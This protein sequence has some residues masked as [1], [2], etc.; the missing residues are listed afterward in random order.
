MGAINDVSADLFRTISF[1]IVDDISAMRSA[2]K[3]LLIQLGA[4]H[5]EQASNGVEALKLLRHGGI[6]VVLSDWNMP[7]MSGIE[8]LQKMRADPVLAKTPFVLV[9]AESNRD[10][11]RK[12]IEAGVNGILVKPFAAAR[13]ADCIQ[14]AQGRAM[15]AEAMPGTVE[16]LPLAAAAANVDR[17]TVLV[18]DD[19]PENLQLMTE[20]MKQDYRVKVANSGDTALAICH[21]ESPP[22]LVLLDIMMPGMDGFE[23][24][25]QLREHPSSEHIPV[26]FVTAMTDEESQAK[27]MALGAVDFVTKPINPDALNIRVRNFMRYVDLRRQ[28][29]ADYDGMLENARLREQV[30]NMT[31]HDLKGPISG[32]VGLA[33]GL[34]ATPGL[35]HESLAQLKT[36]EETALEVIDMI[37][38]STEL[39]KIE[40]GV[41][42][43]A[44]ERV[45]VV[46]LLRAQADLV[47][48]GFAVKSLTTEI[49]TTGGDAVPAISGD[50]MLCRSLFQNLLKNACEAAPEQSS[51]RIAVAAGEPVQISITNSGT[52]PAEIR[53]RFF[54][55]FASAGKTRGSGLGTYSAKLLTEAQKGRIGMRTCDETNQTTIVVALPPA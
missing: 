15:P 2:V 28:L 5:V 17:A 55:K 53:D 14:R 49:E 39:Y 42:R 21:S 1:L 51:I 46:D 34:A 29:Q 54:D 45:E 13:L 44:P 8:L 40:T 27:S 25:R 11:I 43:L 31:R 24:A 9:T 47:V 12:A 38:R 7:V 18:V 33:Q 3:T 35:A 32:I 20:I 41:F 52:V 19:T 4:Q 26:I 50:R 48:A 10:Q 6:D 36:I 22:D 23:V 16:P 30:E 37:T